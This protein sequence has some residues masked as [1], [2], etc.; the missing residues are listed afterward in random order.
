[1]H[2]V[3]SQSSHCLVKESQANGLKRFT[4]LHL[5]ILFFHSH[6]TMHTSKFPINSSW[7]MWDSSPIVNTWI[8]L[9]FIYLSSPFISQVEYPIWENL[10]EPYTIFLMPY[11]Y[12]LFH[13]CLLYT[14]W[15]LPHNPRLRQSFFNGY[16]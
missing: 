2:Y 9:W 13:I 4:Y 14:L 15:P 6:N 5:Y 10:I 7:I 16:A 12:T 8:H 1:M 11:A 3:C